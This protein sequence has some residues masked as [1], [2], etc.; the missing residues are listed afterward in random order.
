VDEV[1]DRLRNNDIDM[2]SVAQQLEN[3]GIEKFLQ[4][5]DQLLKAI[6]GKRKEIIL[7]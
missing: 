2:D 4:P 1:L 3:E 6:E 5:Y 7:Q